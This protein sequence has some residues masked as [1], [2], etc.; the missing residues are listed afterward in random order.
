MMMNDDSD[1]A[2]DPRQSSI[3]DDH[4]DDNNNNNNPISSIIE[5][6]PVDDHHHLPPQQQQPPPSSSSSISWSEHVATRIQDGLLS[7]D[8]PS[9]AWIHQVVQESDGHVTL[10]SQC[11]GTLPP[12]SWSRDFRKAYTLCLWIKPQIFVLPREEG[13]DVDDDDPAAAA[14]SHRTSSTTTTTNAGHLYR[15]SSSANGVGVHVG[16]G[17]SWLYHPD[18]HVIETHLTAYTLPFVPTSNLLQQATTGGATL[19]S[20][21]SNTASS[22]SSA[23]GS[24][25]RCPLRLSTSSWNLLCISHVFPYLQRPTWTCT[26]NGQVLGKGELTYPSL[27]QNN[28]MMDHNT[29]WSHVS[30]Q[31]VVL[32]DNDDNDNDD[33]PIQSPLANLTTSSTSSTTT[34]KTRVHFQIQHVCLYQDIPML[35]SWQALVAEA[36]VALCAQQVGHVLP[37]LP[38]IANWTK[39]NSSLEGGQVGVP[40]IVHSL[41]LEVQRAS[42][43]YLRVCGTAVCSQRL[44]GHKVIWTNTRGWIPGVT[45]ATPRVGLLQPQTPDANNATTSATPLSN[46]DGSG[47]TAAVIWTGP[48]QDY[49]AMYH[50]VVEEEES[51]TNVIT[52]TMDLTDTFSL[53][54]AEQGIPTMVVMSMFLA[55]NQTTLTFASSSSSSVDTTH[56]VPPFM[57]PAPVAFYYQQSVDQLFRLY[58]ISSPSPPSSTLEKNTTTTTT[59]TTLVAQ[60]IEIVALSLEHGGARIQEEVLQNGVLQMLSCCLRLGLLRAQRLGVNSNSKKSSSSSSN[61]NAEMGHGSQASQES[62]SPKYIP[63]DVARACA[64]VLNV[65]CGGTV[66]DLTTSISSSNNR[67]KKKKKNKNTLIR[68]EDLPPAV[69]IRRT[70]DLALTALFSLALDWDLWGSDATAAHVILEP[71]SQWYGSC[72]TAGYMLRSQISVQYYLDMIRLRWDHHSNNSFKQQEQQQQRSKASGATAPNQEHDAASYLFSLDPVELVAQ[73][74]VLMLRA[75]LVSSLTNRRSISQSEYDIAACMTALSDSPLG[76]VTAHVV[77]TALYGVLEWCEIVPKQELPGDNSSEETAGDESFWD[78]ADSTNSEAKLQVASR[79]G[80][81]LLVGQFHD[82]VAPMLLSRTVFCAERSMQQQVQQQQKQAAASNNN[83]HNRAAPSTT[84]K[85]LSWQHHWR[86]VMLIYSWITAIAGP[87]GEISAK[88]TGGLMLAS[89]LAGSL[90]GA[91][92]YFGDGRESMSKTLVPALFLPPS[93]MALMVAGGGQSRRGKS[94]NNWSY[95]DLLADRLK[96]MMPLVPGMVVALLGPPDALSHISD[97]AFTALADILTAMAGSFHRVFGGLVHSARL[98]SPQSDYRRAGSL[99]GQPQHSALVKAAKEYAPHLVAIIMLV[100]HHIQLRKIKFDESAENK[101]KME[102]IEILPTPHK[103]TSG[104][105]SRSGTDPD[106]WIDVSNTSSSTHEYLMSD[107]SVELPSEAETPEELIVVRLRA[108]QKSALTIISELVVSTMRFRGGEASTMIWRIVLE[109]LRDSSTYSS[110]MK[111]TGEM[112]KSVDLDPFARNAL[113]RLVALTLVKTLKRDFGWELWNAELC[114]AVTRLCN[115]VEEKELLVKPI[116]GRG[117]S[118][119]PRFSRDQVVLMGALAAVLEYG[120]VVTGWCQLILPTPPLSSAR[121]MPPTLIH[122]FDEPEGITAVASADLFGEGAFFGSSAEDTVVASPQWMSQSANQRIQARDHLPPSAS[123]KLML[124]LLQPCLRVFMSCFATVNSELN[125][126]IPETE[127]VV[128]SGEKQPIRKRISLLQFMGAELKE[129]LIAAVVGLSFANAR[130]VA[131]NAL[132]WLRRALLLHRNN[133]DENAENICSG[134]FGVVV[135]ELRVR[136]EGERRLREKALFDAYDDDDGD[137]RG[138]DLDGLRQSE[139]EASRAVER[140][141]L[142]GDLIPAP[143]PPKD[144]IEE[145]SFETKKKLV[146]SDDFVLF[147]VPSNEVQSGSEKRGQ[148]KLGWTEYEGLGAALDR[149]KSTPTLSSED[150]SAESPESDADFLVSILTPFLDKWDEI[151]ARDAADSELVEIFASGLGV[152]SDDRFSTQGPSSE[153]N[154][155]IPGSEA[156]ADAMSTFFEFAASEKSR[157]KELSFTFLPNHRHSSMAFTERFCLARYAELASEKFSMHRLW[158]RA[159]SDGNRDVRSRLATVPCHPQFKRYIPKYLDNTASFY[160]ENSSETQSQLSDLRELG[161]GRRVP[162]TSNDIDLIT[163]TLLEAGNLEIKDITKQEVPDDDGKDLDI[164]PRNPDEVDFDDDDV[165]GDGSL[166]FPSRGQ[167]GSSS[168][169]GDDMELSTGGPATIETSESA[170]S[171]QQQGTLTAADKEYERGAYNHAVNASSFSCPPDNSSSTLSLVQS[172]AASMIEEHLENC[173]HVKAEGTRKCSILLTATHLILE[174]DAE[175]AGMFEGEMMAVQEEAERHKMIQEAGG[176]SHEDSQ[177]DRAL[178]ELEQRHRE[179]AALRPRSIRWNLSEVSH[180][181]LRRY[182][183]RDSALEV[184]F[185][186]SGGS[187]FG[188]YGIFSPSSSLFLDLGSGHEGNIRRDDIAYAVMKRAPPQA[189][190]QWPDR[191]GQFLHDQLSRL[192]I[193]WVEGRITN[194]DYLL[195][196]NML[197]GRSYNDLCQYPVMPWVLSDYKSEQIPDLDDPA[198]YRDLSKPMGAINPERLEEFIERFSTFADPTIPPFMYGSHYSTS[199]GVVLHFLVRMHPFAGLHRQLQGGHFDVADRLFSSIPRTWEMCTG[200]SAAEVK[201]LTPEW[202]CNPNFLRNANAFKLGTSQDGELLGDV[203]LP[204]WAQNSP[205]KFVEV[206]RSA[207]E[208]DVCSQMLPDWIDLIFGRKQQGPEAIKANNVFFYLTYYGSVDLASI[209]DE[210]LR[211]ATELQ[212][213]HFGQCPMQ[214]LVR[215]HV[216]RLP[217]RHFRKMSLYQILSPYTRRDLPKIGAEYEP[218]ELSTRERIRRVIGTPVFLPFLSAP[219]SHWVH[220]DAPPPGPHAPLVAVRLAGVDRCL[221]VDA[222]GV[223]HCFRWAWKTDETMEMTETDNGPSDRGCFVAQRELARFRSLPRLLYSPAEAAEPGTDMNSIL[224]AV[225]ISKTLFAGRSVLLVLSD[226]DGRGGLALQLVDPAKGVVKG[227]ALIKGC[228]SGRITCIATEPMGTAAGHG[229]VGGELAIVGA[230]DGSAS[231]WRFMSSHYLPLRPRVRLK[232]HGGA[233]LYAVALSSA[234]HVC[235]TVSEKRCCIHSTGNGAIIRSLDPP[236]DTFELSESHTAPDVSITTTFADT[237]ALVISVQGFIVT[238]CKSIVRSESRPSLNRTV[239]TLHLLTLEG[240]SLGSQPLESWRGVPHSMRCTPDGT[241]VFVCSGR[242]IT[243]H[244]LSAIAPLDFIDEWQVTEMI[245]EMNAGVKIPRAYDIDLGPSLMRPIIAAAACS[246]G[247]LRLHALPG[248]STWS[249]RY[250]RNT[251]GSSVGSVLAKPAQRLKSAM[252]KSF[253]FGTKVVGMGKEIGREVTN[254]VRERGVGGFLGNVIFRKSAK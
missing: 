194:F 233:K 198:N 223:F 37:T 134:L 108:C 60:L 112:N 242:G 145:V 88:S 67:T 249:E 152:E 4:D 232:G 181:Y 10:N 48:V 62:T 185:I 178:D 51:T 231:L 113:C 126:L 26:V 222:Q 96:I 219:L 61:A 151:L 56:T 5:Q 14:S 65:C 70:S 43:H 77:L 184:F 13:H 117:E 85:L 170:D 218:V 72:P 74:L 254:D 234:I 17:E 97:V 31:V 230:S 165:Y 42:R 167:S 39:G 205:E 98:T 44:G 155:L 69:L 210:G 83:L 94:N 183:L 207:L 50:H 21:P 38:P 146:G 171:L 71:I 173:L 115:L 76:S 57:A 250:K 168:K 240:V 148:A 225:A 79:L 99:R 188:G 158:E 204:P 68:W 59:T 226:G 139:A 33:D 157:L 195:H 52:T 55:L 119:Q 80:R 130:D 18:D 164:L 149:C 160:S 252:S 53:L 1:A 20:F 229:G 28:S 122:S 206:M 162:N 175:T 29:I 120:R 214:L 27:D 93:A 22:S 124:P 213:A 245:E 135:E 191:S 40:L 132:A 150:R 66:T 15:F 100:E 118:D 192:T 172:A 2:V 156:A 109:T 235:A 45:E 193:G 19:L 236:T 92:T 47:T 63:P 121:N 143:T 46:S 189:I 41:A 159:I 197:A 217:M 190:K 182:R 221:A 86:M 111:K 81:N 89:G 199:A 90:S 241:A 200:A 237:P 239:L 201:E 11:R 91:L 176:H 9:L 208:S 196:L 6:E 209:E 110:H 144:L 101:V 35:P 163:K 73:D 224:P 3:V 133:N 174:Y 220:L 128:Q 161:E 248:I 186:P 30:E 34:T 58:R 251:L 202:Y 180:V 106:S 153:H 127:S 12:L 179:A 212:I 177:K 102:D 78:S 238:A 137:G 244:R 24:L 166:G 23:S 54:L 138:T 104:T 169:H 116:G 247:V 75:M 123:S 246:S 211:Q 87:E 82:V 105:R 141:I 216:R 131:L 140:L 8:P 243:I 107:G 32:Q 147:H 136:Y 25:V 84:R 49:H 125:I 64:H 103:F 114:S 228:H 36:G 253:G 95:T 203:I 227:E 215:P 129:S 154:I 142:G 7:F 16:M 187:S